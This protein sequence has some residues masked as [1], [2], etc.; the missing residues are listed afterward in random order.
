[1]RKRK[2][3]ALKYER[4]YREDI[5]DCLDLMRISEELRRGY[6]ELWPHE[7]LARNGPLNV[8]R[9]LAGPT[10]PNFPSAR[11]LSL[12]RGIMSRCARGLIRRII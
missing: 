11:I 10:I 1:V 4:L 12:T 7:H 6:N 5:A 9:G 3:Q 8:H 2:F